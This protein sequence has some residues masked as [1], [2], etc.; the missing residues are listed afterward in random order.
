MLRVAKD[1]GF[2]SLFLFDEITNALVILANLSFFYQTFGS[3]HQ[4]SGNFIKALIKLPK[5]L[6]N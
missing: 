2:L 5:A 4:C 6:M 3:G 1:L